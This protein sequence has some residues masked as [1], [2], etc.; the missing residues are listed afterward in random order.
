MQLG[1]KKYLFELIGT[2]ALVTM[3]CASIMLTQKVVFDLLVPFTFGLTY[4]ILYVFIS[5][6]SGCHINPAVTIAMLIANKIDKIQALWYIVFQFVGALLASTIL[7]TVSSASYDFNV[8]EIN[9]G[10]NKFVDYF[11]NNYT[12]VV[13]FLIEVFF[14]TL[15]VYVTLTY[16]NSK[17]IKFSAFII[18]L[19]LFLIH[20]VGFSITSVSVNPARSFGP[21]LLVGGIAFKQLWVFFLAPFVG[22]VIGSLIWKLIEINKEINH[23]INELFKENK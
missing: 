15:L 2:M 23:K 14:S 13:T 4:I 20:L 16:S 5:P 6:V 18:G 9:I 22:S 19:T 3:G 12:A 21:A 7:Y 11:G 8:N 17:N 1:I 10:Q